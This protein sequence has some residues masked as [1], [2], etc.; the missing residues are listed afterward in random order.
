MTKYVRISITFTIENEKGNKLY[1]KLSPGTLGNDLKY[2]QQSLMAELIAAILIHL[3]DQIK[4]TEMKDMKVLGTEKRTVVT[5]VGAMEINRR[6]YRT[7]DGK[8][9]KPLDQLLGIA[10]YERRN[11]HCL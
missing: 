10:P 6:V 9:V 4:E 8:R 7:A 5:E 1:F 2:L 11:R 3:I